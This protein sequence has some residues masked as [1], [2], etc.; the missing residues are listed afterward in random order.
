MEATYLLERERKRKG[1]NCL[2]NRKVQKR[3][4]PRRKYSAPKEKFEKLHKYFKIPNNKKN[5]KKTE[6]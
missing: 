3:L 5:I 2:E 6:K 1:D 4:G